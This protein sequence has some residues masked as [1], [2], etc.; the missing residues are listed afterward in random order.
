MKANTEDKLGIIG[1][2]IGLFVGKGIDTVVNSE[3]SQ[4]AQAKV[5]SVAKSLKDK[6]L[7]AT[8][9]VREQIAEDLAKT[10]VIKTAVE[11]LKKG[12]Q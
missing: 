9:K 4:K 5:G 8:Q 7:T 10:E 12:E 6:F 2:Q 11:N 1:A 3:I